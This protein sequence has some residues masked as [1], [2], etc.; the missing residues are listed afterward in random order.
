M[1]SSDVATMMRRV[2]EQESS[3]GSVGSV[4]CRASAAAVVL[5]CGVASAESAK[6]AAAADAG[7]RRATTALRLGVHLRVPFALIGTGEFA[8]ADLAAEGL[9]AGV[10][11]DVGRQV[12]TSRE[13]SHAD[14]ALKPTR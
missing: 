10:R 3:D 9:L 13:G 8:T 12:V 2:T 4:R 1:R 6:R 11:A 14:A 5:R 7:D